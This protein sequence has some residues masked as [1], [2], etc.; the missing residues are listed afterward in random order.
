MTVSIF[1]DHMAPLTGSF[2]ILFLDLLY[3]LE[4]DI[5]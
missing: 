1:R 3:M 4:F 2:D 5:I